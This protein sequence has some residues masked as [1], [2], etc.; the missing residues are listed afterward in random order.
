LGQAEQLGLWWRCVGCFDQ[1]GVDWTAKNQAGESILHVVAKL[2]GRRA[3]RAAQFLLSKG[4]NPH[5]KNADGKTLI[6][7]ARQLVPENLNY[8][9]TI[10]EYIE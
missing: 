9:N 10:L 5:E 1:A 4:L 3:G 8:G 6:N 2:E 7:I